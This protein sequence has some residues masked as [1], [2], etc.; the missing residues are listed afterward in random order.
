MTREETSCLTRRVSRKKRRPPRRPRRR[1]I[2]AASSR[3]RRPRAQVR[4]WVRLARRREA[5]E[6]LPEADPLAR[7]AGQAK[8]AARPA[9]AAA[10]VKVEGP[11]TPD[12]ERQ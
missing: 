4:R 9:R 2:S 1:W 6:A 10:R 8:V 3:R 7:V 5:R 12:T 11:E